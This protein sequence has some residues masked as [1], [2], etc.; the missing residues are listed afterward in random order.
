MP[1]WPVSSIWLRSIRT[2]REPGRVAAACVAAVLIATVVGAC[3]PAGTGSTAGPSMAQ[4]DPATDKL[5]SILAR[6]TLVLATDLEYPPQSFAVEGASRPADTKC[7]DN[8]LTGSEV[9]GYDA[10]TGKAVA[11]AL[12]VEPCFV[13]PPWSQITAGNWGDH[14]DVAWGSG[15]V[16]DDRM[17]RLWMTQPYYA[18]PHEFFVRDDSAVEDPA[19]LSGATVGA[20]TGCTHELYLRHEL[21]LPGPP[22]D[23][24]VDD[25][26]IVTFDAE[27]AGLAALAEG[28]LDAFLAGEPV[29]AEAISAGLPLRM[30]PEPAYH[31]QKSGYLDR[32][33][34]LGQGPLF[35]RIN[36]ILAGLHEDG[37]LRASSEGYFGVD[38]ATAAGESD[39]DALGQAVP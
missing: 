26:L 25:P 5:A 4:A 29:G 38:D 37:T 19:D 8:Q 23:Y 24:A 36:A 21:V 10:D 39:L 9:A 34:S 15:A 6:G 12:G 27:P 20:C 16:T 30:L 31:T 13:T 7:A 18:T 11:E 35:E 32:A 17:T 1:L 2:C 14:W 33:S 22:L 3:A 28:E